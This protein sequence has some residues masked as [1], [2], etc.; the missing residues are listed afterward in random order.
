MEYYGGVKA[1]VHQGFF[2]YNWIGVGTSLFAESSFQP[3]SISQLNDLM[4]HS[5]DT[6]QLQSLY[7]QLTTQKK[8]VNAFGLV[9]DNPKLL[10]ED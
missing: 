8:K 5:L 9:L 2:S 10:R 3:I 6:H 7:R 4:G 1:L